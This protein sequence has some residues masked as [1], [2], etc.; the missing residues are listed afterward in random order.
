VHLPPVTPLGIDHNMI[1]SKKYNDLYNLLQNAPAHPR[2]VP[3]LSPHILPHPRRAVTATSR[4]PSSPWPWCWRSTAGGPFP[5]VDRPA[6]E[7]HIEPA[8]GS[9]IAR[10]VGGSLGG[11]TRPLAG[12]LQQ[13]VGGSAG[14]RLGW[15][16]GAWDTLGRIRG[17]GDGARPR[18]GPSLGW[19]DRRGSPPGRRNGAGWIHIDSSPW[20]MGLRVGL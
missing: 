10:T 5:R 15:L 18:A 19:M 14:S 20:C 8:H 9:P 6:L 3:H 2:T 16:G 1:V 13:L 17:E 12:P 4:M 11:R 7:I